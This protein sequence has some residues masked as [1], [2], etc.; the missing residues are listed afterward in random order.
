MVGKM[1]VTEVLA[2]ATSF[3]TAETIFT[4]L[5]T[6]G[7]Q[8]W[9]LCWGKSYAPLWIRCWQMVRQSLYGRCSERDATLV[10]HFEDTFENQL[11]SNISQT[12]VNYDFDIGVM[13]ESLHPG[14]PNGF[15][16]SWE[17]SICE[18]NL[19]TNFEAWISYVKSAQV[20]T[21]KSAICRWLNWYIVIC[22]GLTWRF[23]L[24]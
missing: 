4:M 14:W 1:E 10:D 3:W 9:W 18:T 7:C 24:I 19:S 11:V 16:T 2:T 15:S 22:S 6:C 20:I 21:I 17:S 12:F 5:R 13:A 8:V 23:E